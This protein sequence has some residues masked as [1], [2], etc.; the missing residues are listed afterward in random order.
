MEWLDEAVRHHEL[1]GTREFFVSG[2]EITALLRNVLAST[3]RPKVAINRPQVERKRLV[4][5]VEWRGL[6]FTS[7]TLRPI[8]LV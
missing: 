7:V 6:K 8:A 3:A 4:H 2:E 5:T 1:L